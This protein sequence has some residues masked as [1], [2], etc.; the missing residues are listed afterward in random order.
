[1]EFELLSDAPLFAMDVLGAGMHSASEF[2]APPEWGNSMNLNSML[3]EVSSRKRGYYEATEDSRDSESYSSSS[4]GSMSPPFARQGGAVDGWAGDH[5]DAFS[6]LSMMSA[7]GASG[8]QH[9]AAA[10]KPKRARSASFEAILK[11]LPDEGL[12]GGGGSRPAPSEVSGFWAS[13]P[14]DVARESVYVFPLATDPS[15]A[16]T[17]TSSPTTMPLQP[18]HMS[19]PNSN[20]VESIE[21][22]NFL[23]PLSSAERQRLRSA[24][25]GAA[26]IRVNCDLSFA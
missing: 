11:D 25:H 6:P 15:Q 12:G 3:D 22:P 7:Y 24:G 10:Q 8:Q 4:V 14:P 19:K 18:G 23:K 16:R 26:I 17:P 5:D 2:A 13:A 9:G 1:M 21:K 20:L